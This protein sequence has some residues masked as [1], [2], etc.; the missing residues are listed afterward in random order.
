MHFRLVC[1][2]F[3]I[4]FQCKYTTWFVYL[5]LQNMCYFAQFS[6]CMSS[7]IQLTCYLS[8]VCFSILMFPVTLYFY[9]SFLKIDNKVYK[10]RCRVRL[11]AFI[12]LPGKI[13]SSYSET[14]NVG[15][16]TNNYLLVRP[17][18]WIYYCMNVFISNTLFL[19]PRI[20]YEYKN[21]ISRYTILVELHIHV[22]L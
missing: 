11:D 13:F 7:C 20:N 19:L 12:V 10:I 3:A 4:N 5:W 18:L 9:V 22:Y 8:F 6:M 17:N 2:W 21:A 14:W 15:H 1:I 16:V